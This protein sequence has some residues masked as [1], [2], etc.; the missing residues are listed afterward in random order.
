MTANAFLTTAKILHKLQDNNNAKKHVQLA[1][2][3]RKEEGWDKIPAKLA[4]VAKDLDISL[5]DIDGESSKLIEELKK[6]W[7]DKLN[8]FVKNLPV[9]RGKIKTILPKGGGFIKG[10]D[11]GDIF[12]SKG[13]FHGNPNNLII[14]MSVQYNV[15]D[16][17]DKKKKKKSKSAYNIKNIN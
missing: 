11:G 2:L 1:Y 14:D 8:D 10:E 3:L 12:F 13:D 6:Y 9:Y 5:D 16:S 17:Y 7:N 4:Q 15:K